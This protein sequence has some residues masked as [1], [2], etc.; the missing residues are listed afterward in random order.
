MTIELAA[1]V[2]LDRIVGKSTTVV[3]P[4]G[5]VAWE[6]MAAALKLKLFPTK[7]KQFTRKIVSKKEYKPL[8]GR[9]SNYRQGMAVPQ[10]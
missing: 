8:S 1:Y 6:T 3:Y 7:Q 5:N 9:H 10:K 2:M 4:D